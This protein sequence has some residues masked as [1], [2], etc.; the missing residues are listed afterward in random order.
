M[1]EMEQENHPTRPR[2]DCDMQSYPIKEYPELFFHQ[3]P[4]NT[5]CDAWI[6][7]LAIIERMSLSEEDT[8]IPFNEIPPDQ[9]CDIVRLPPTIAKLN[10][11]KHVL[12]YGSHLTRIPYEVGEMESLEQFY[13]YT[14]HSLHWFP[15]EITRCKNLKYSTI[16][17]RRLYGNYK[18][19]PPFP[20]LPIMW[21][22]IIPKT[23]SVC[24][25]P[26][27]RTP[28]QCWISL[29]VATDVMPLLVHA[30]SRSCIDSLPK[31]ATGYFPFPHAGGPNIQQP[32]PSYI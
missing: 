25:R 16:S 10:K 9:W 18:F 4:Q 29:L 26:F 2:C 1:S 22:E 27:D 31:P 32:R 30:C 23:C 7:L 14:S 19:R 28:I 15:Y 17:T 20:K 11:V 6:Q 8:L 3:E 5:D 24:N 12:F 21:D 13:V